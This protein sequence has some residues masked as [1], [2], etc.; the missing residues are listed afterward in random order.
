M[1]TVLLSLFF[2]FF[3]S[4]SFLKVNT[5]REVGKVMGEADRGDNDAGCHGDQGELG[6]AACSERMIRSSSPL[7]MMREVHIRWTGAQTESRKFSSSKT[8]RAAT[9]SSN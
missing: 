4:S 2:F 1:S 5:T 3:Y 7:V 8:Q 6:D 9:G